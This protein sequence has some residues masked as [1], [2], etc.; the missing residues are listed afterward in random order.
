[1]GVTPNNLCYVVYTSGSTGRP[2]GVA[3]THAA[4]TAMLLWQQRTSSAKAG[5]TLQFTSLSFDV[6]F[7]EIFSTWWAGGTLVLV[8][9]DVRR[10][11][12]ALA[13]LLA[14]QRIER[15]FLPFVALQQLAMAA[16]EGELPLHLREVMSAGEQL[17]VTP[18]VAELFSRLPGAELHNHYGPSETH[19]ATWLDLHG[20][21]SRWPERPPIGV[22]L[23]H[24]R[25]FLLDADLNPVPAGVA[26]EVWVG[27]PGLAR[28]YLDRPHLTAERFLPDPFHWAGGWKPGDRLYRTGDLARRRP[29]GILEFLGRRDSQVKIRGQRIELF[30]VETAL[31]RHPAVQQAAAGVRGDSSGSR[32]LVGY[33]VLREGTAAPKFGELRS[34][35][36]E[37]L[38]DVMVPT[39]W[40]LLEALPLTPTGKLDRRVLARIEPQEGMGD[41]E[42]FVGPRTPAE[43][44]L[45]MVWSE[46][47]G[48]PRVSA[49]DDFFQLGGHSLLATQVASRIREEFGVDLPLRRIFE[50]STLSAMAAAIL[51]ADGAPAAP[52]IRKAP[53]TGDLPLSFAQ[54]RLWVL[55]RIQ[56]GGSA[57]NVPLILTAEGKLDPKRLATALSAVVR[58]HEVLRTVFAERDGS[59]VQVIQPPAPVPVPVVD[60]AGLEEEARRLA[61]E[62]AVRPF[63]LAAGPLLRAMVLKLAP[64]RSL[65]LLNLHHIVTDGWSMGVL[66]REVNALYSGERLPEL[67]VQYAD[68][69]VW[70]RRWLSGE[71]LDRQIAWWRERLRGAPVLEL[72]AEHPRPPVQTQRGAELRFELDSR[73]VELAREEGVTPFMVL[74]GGL[75]ALLSRLTGQADVPIGSPIANRNRIETEGLIGFFVN[76]LVL[77][78]DLSRAETFRDLLRQ[79]REAS[80]GAYAHQDVPFEKL[81]D[82]LHPDRDLSRSPLFQVALALQNAP[83]PAAD[84]GDVRLAS[85]EIHTGVAKFDLSFVFV[86]DGGRF[87]GLLQYAT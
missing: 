2:K 72:P 34:F 35:L 31:A 63:D 1:E 27:G 49:L 13:R 39:A 12:P 23:D 50:A 36:A 42:T 69:A 32:R 44:L 71:V 52:P 24:T 40:A 37:S 73:I 51:D 65:V 8:S 85:E 41:G 81:V 45:A 54:E 19:A 38:P 70:Q 56:P 43:E 87:A 30:E 25:L 84:L 28:G 83:L 62:E 4:I 48:V 78:A 11:P 14:E 66:V 29:D 59:P 46:V 15:L 10:D 80:L 60:L 22:P 33:V 67:P 58:R 47:L 77:R 16:L 55:D 17:Y 9:D 3:M 18:Q 75:S 61:E 76:T 82:E 64:E 79:V 6:S 57:Y 20:D 68:F 53:R 26:G 86:E 7:Q 21:P 5:R 74:A